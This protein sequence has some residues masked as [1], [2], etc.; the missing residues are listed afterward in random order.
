MGATFDSEI[1]VQVNLDAPPITRAGF[2]TLL[3]VGATAGFAAN[4]VRAYST[5]A[6]VAADA[7]LSVLLA[8]MA[9]A[10]FAQTLRPAVVKV[11]D[12]ALFNATNLDAIMANDSAWFGLAITSRVAADILAVATWAN[13]AGR[14]FM[15]QSNDAAILATAYVAAA[16]TDVA[17]NLKDAGE[18]YA[19]LL[20]HHDDA[21]FADVA[22]MANRLSVNP[23]RRTST[24]K[25]V[26]LVGVTISVITST[27]KANAQS[28]NCNLV[29]P[30]FGTSATGEGITMEGASGRFI[31]LVVTAAWVKARVEEALAQLLL[32]VVNAGRKIPY[33][34]GGLN[35]FSN[36]VLKVLK[37]GTFAGHF[38]A[39]TEQVVMPALA[40]VPA[41]D[42]AARTIN[43]TF[44]AEPA[45]AIHSASLVGYV[46]LDLGLLVDA[47]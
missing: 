18:R 2:T 30:F 13:S 39:G 21:E 11:G 31:D 27:Q 16:G 17:N 7:D 35:T 20:Y 44:G 32:N 6:E 45:G 14:L 22:W 41:P 38:V 42:R 29:L 10:A 25:F 34:D 4:E 28:K 5:P 33:D 9:T 12:A 47:A 24:W 37:Q 19:G 3:I 46:A 8:A 40:D 1:S 43:F 36:A 26:T 23:D 15:G